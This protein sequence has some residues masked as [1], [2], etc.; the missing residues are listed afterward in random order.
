MRRLLATAVVPLVLLAGVGCSTDPDPAPPGADPVAPVGPAVALP[1]AGASASQVCA[2][3][4]QAG[5]LAV[6][7]YVDELGRM[8]AAT[9]ADDAPGAQAARDRAGAALTGWRSALRELSTRATDP[10]LKTLLTDMAD[11]VEAKGADVDEIDEVDLERLRQ[12]LDP[13]C[14]R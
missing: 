12:R 4:Q 9:G 7:T 3:A 11:E 5:T 13:L 8:V 1:S 10:P 6:Q 2:A 14:A